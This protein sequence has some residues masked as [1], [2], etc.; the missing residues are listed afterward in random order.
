M[1][2]TNPIVSYQYQVLRYRPDAVSGEFVNVGLVY[3]DPTQRLLKAKMVDK[4]KRIS[5]FFTDVPGT[6]LLRSLKQLGNNAQQLC[7]QLAQELDFSK[8][9][10][11]EQVTASLLPKDDNGLYFSETFRGIHFDHEASFQ[12]LYHR[13]VEQYLEQTI[14]RHDDAYAW[15]HVY[16]SFFDKYQLTD[17]LE[18]KT[19]KTATDTFDFERAVKNGALHCFQTVSFDLKN[20]AEVKNKIYL[21]NARIEELKTAEQAV[22]LYL[23][24]LLP[25]NRELVELLQKKL[26]IDGG[27]VEVELVKESGAEKV[28][29]EVKERLE[30]VH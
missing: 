3:Y 28:I 19:V 27:S 25:E 6:F 29:K 24:T 9:Q 1:D 10:T 30:G 18:H 26:D 17:K 8:Y 21:W 20:E 4:Y 15:R 11:I 12:E 2:T 14:E 22:K 16:K 13:I 7:R 5:Q 23:L